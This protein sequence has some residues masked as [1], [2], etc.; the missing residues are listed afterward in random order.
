M[1]PLPA[2]PDV[3]CRYG[4]LERRSI[5]IGLGVTMNS[6][7]TEP[8]NHISPRFTNIPWANQDG[9]FSVLSRK[10]D[11]IAERSSEPIRWGAERGPYLAPIEQASSRVE[12][13][14]APVHRK[15]LNGQVL[16]ANQRHAWP[17]WLVCQF[18]RTSAILLDI[19]GIPE[20][21]LGHL[22]LDSSL[23]PFL[24]SDNA[25][26]SAVRNVLS[27]TGSMRLV[28]PIVLRDWFIYRPPAGTSSRATIRL[29]SR[30][31]SPAT[32]L[33]LFTPCLPSSALRLGS[34]M[35]FRPRR[36]RPSSYLASAS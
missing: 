20:Q 28:V 19:A 9:R 16:S 22:R 3:G 32:P 11:K 30:V 33:G 6:A 36:Y 25:I 26:R 35:A 5:T 13:L 7:G 18:V 12:N 23:N 4:S 34:S 15:L 17:Y 27:I 2:R 31:I 8:R 24:N 1:L 10:G 21:I 14:V 29:R